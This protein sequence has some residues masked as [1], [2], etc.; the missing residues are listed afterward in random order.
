M[1][2]TKKPSQPPRREGERAW[3]GAIGQTVVTW[4]QTA[5]RSI[6]QSGQ[7]HPATG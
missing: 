5:F 2:R 6:W 3:V 4:V 7:L 1:S